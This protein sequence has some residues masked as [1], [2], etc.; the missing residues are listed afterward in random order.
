MKDFIFTSCSTPTFPY[1]YLIR[2]KIR[3]NTYHFTNEQAEMPV[4][5][6]KLAGFFDKPKFVDS[7]R[8]KSTILTLNNWI[9]QI[10]KS[11]FCIYSYPSFI[12]FQ[13]IIFICPLFV[14]TPILSSSSTVILGMRVKACSGK[15]N[16]V[17]HEVG[18]NSGKQGTCRNESRQPHS[19]RKWNIRYVA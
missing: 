15:W 13:T 9:R 7:S 2:A 4:K 5:W 6:E 10:F 16:S 17:Q 12:V 18:W 1:D 19:G 3:E 11:A 14:L 8:T